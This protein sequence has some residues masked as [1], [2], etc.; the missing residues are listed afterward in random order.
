MKAENKRGTVEVA[1]IFD[2]YGATYLK[3]HKLCLDQIK[4]FHAITNCRTAFMG[5]HLQA[6]DHCGHQRPAYNS[7]RNRHCP[8]CQYIKQVQWVDKL[9]SIFPT[10][11]YFH[12]VFTIPSEL[13]KTFYINQRICYDLLFKA[14]ATTLKKAGANPLF[15]GAETGAVAI[16]HTWGQTLTYHPHIHM[17][18]PAGG[19]SPDQTEWVPAGKKFFLPVKALSKI[20]RAIL[21]RKIGEDIAGGS[22]K[23]PDGVIS[24]DSL[25]KDLY[26]KNWNV[27]SKKALGGPA[28]VVGY[29]GKYTHRVAISNSRILKIDKGMVT[30]RWKDYRKALMNKYMEIKVEEFISRFLHHILPNGFYKIRYY[31]LLASANSSTK[32][33]L[34]FQLIGKTTYLS[35]LEGLNGLEVMRIVTGEDLSYC[36]VCKKGRMKNKSLNLWKEKP[37]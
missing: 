29:L 25:K 28:S 12:L 14:A 8:K 7:C 23:L 15:L 5:G 4:A 22:I 34:I 37:S 19:L 36:P 9:T 27:F 10:T 31:G 17:I 11:P 18:V 16:L 30:F 21:C 3:T 32:K 24:F 1:D 6:C 13:H 2:Q 35:T 33:E 20:F 26:K